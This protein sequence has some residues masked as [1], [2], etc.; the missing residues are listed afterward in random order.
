MEPPDFRL[1]APTLGI[2]T[3]CAPQWTT[4][5]KNSRAD[6]RSIVSRVPVDVKNRRGDLGIQELHSIAGLERR[7][8]NALDELLLEF[9]VH[10]EKMRRIACDFHHDGLMFRQL[11]FLHRSLQFLHGD[12]VQIDLHTA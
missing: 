7:I 4:F 8:I 12:D 11:G 2:M 3:P 6:S 5:E 9:P 10:N 1:E